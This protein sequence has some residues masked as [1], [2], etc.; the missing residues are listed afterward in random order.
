VICDSLPIRLRW[1]GRTG[2]IAF[3]G[4]HIRLRDRPAGMQWAQVDWAPGTVAICRDRDID[5]ERDLLPDEIKAIE[6]WMRRRAAIARD[7]L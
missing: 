7:G 3:D 6:A 4:V 1:D 5:P 2:C